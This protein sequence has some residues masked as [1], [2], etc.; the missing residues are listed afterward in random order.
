MKMGPHEG[1]SALLSRDTR[2]LALS[3]ILCTRTEEKTM[4]GHREKTAVCQPG[5]LL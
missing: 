1:I 4:G 3:P 5:R 2:E